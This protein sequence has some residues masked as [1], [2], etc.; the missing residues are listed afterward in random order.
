[1]VYLRNYKYVVLLYYLGINIYS[2]LLM[3]IDKRK[4]KKHQWR[5]SEK[6]LMG[7]ALFGGAL[8][9]ILGM[10][11]YHHKTKHQLFRWGSPMFLLLHMFFIL[12]I[13]GFFPI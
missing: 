4:A 11:F 2:F 9:I 12:S 5:V 8:G 13:L 10:K 3:G 1:M 7:T 6:Y